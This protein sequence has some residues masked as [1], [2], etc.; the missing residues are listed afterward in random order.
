MRI[1]KPHF[2]MLPEKAFQPRNGR[3]AF[4][5]GGMTLH[6]CCGPAPAAPAAPT[7]T[8]VQNTNIPCYAKPYVQT[9]LGATTQQLFNTTGS[10][11]CIQITGVKP[12]APYS[13]NPQDYVAGFSPL[14]QK[15]QQ[16]AANLTTPNQYG[17]ATG[18]AAMGSMQALNAG[19]GLQNTLTSAQGIG[20][21]MNPYIQNVLNPALAL[22]NQQY[23]INQAQEQ[24]QATGA[25]AFGGS[26]EALMS[27]LNQQNQMLAN[28]QLIGN[29]YNT[30]Y[31]NAQGAATN[32]AGMNLQGG[33]AGIQGGSALSNI[34]GQ[35]LA[36][37]MNILN[38]QNQAGTAQQQNQQQIINQAVQNYAVAQQY[39]EQQLAFMNA[40]LRGLPLQ[41]STVQ[42]Y[43]A[44]PSAVSQAAGIGTA[45]IAGLGLYNAMSGTSSDIR[46]KENIEFVDILMD[47]INIYEFD[48]KPEFKDKAGHGRY[49][50]VMADEVEQ[51]M[52][53]AVVTDSNGYKYVHYDMLGIQMEQV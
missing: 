13:T 10:G 38:A 3:M 5:G 37:Q 35:C 21:Y 12:Y 36:A 17:A 25:G 7:Q 15:A 48:Y 29:A 27:G 6:G 19:Q 39:P 8:T 46:V 53:Q 1:K 9:M 33:Q 11:C 43:N 2:G 22:S 41:S 34:G 18:S 20:Q 44:A 52:P 45:G 26:R 47:G 42:Q 50:G 16:G 4:A 14:Q 40:Q 49:R 24:G 28:N 31:N 23:G 32:V 30:A 51:I